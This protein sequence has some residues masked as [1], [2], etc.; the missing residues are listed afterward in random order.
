MTRELVLLRDVDVDES[1][2][3]FERARSLARSLTSSRARVIDTSCSSFPLRQRA[4]ARSSHVEND[5]DH[6]LPIML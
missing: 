2:L 6:D 3:V 5:H 4:R 1:S